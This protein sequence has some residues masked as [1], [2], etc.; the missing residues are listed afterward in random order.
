MAECANRQGSEIAGVFP[1]ETEVLISAET[2]RGTD[3]CVGAIDATTRRQTRINPLRHQMYKSPPASPLGLVYSIG[4][5]RSGN[6]LWAPHC[7]AGMDLVTL[8]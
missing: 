6:S 1:E 2:F 7:P 8:G 5:R 3:F 4:T